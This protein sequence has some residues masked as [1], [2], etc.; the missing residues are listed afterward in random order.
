MF[1]AR[2]LR[3]ELRSRARQAVMIALGLALGVGLVVT[4]VAASSGVQQAQGRV[5]AGLYAW[6]PT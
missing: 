1:F 6:A 5:L 3:C 2:Y 4:V